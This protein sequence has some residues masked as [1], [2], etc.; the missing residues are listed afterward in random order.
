MIRCPYYSAETDTA[1]TAVICEPEKNGEKY[2]DVHT[3]TDPQKRENVINHFCCANYAEC[4]YYKQYQ[5]SGCSNDADNAAAVIDQTVSGEDVEFNGTLLVSADV[6]TA[7]TPEHREAYDL[8]RHIV[9][10]GITA[11]TAIADMGRSLKTMRDGKLY[12]AMGYETFGDYVENNGDYSFKERQ[13]YNY[14][15]IYENCGEHFLQTNAAIGVTKLELLSKLER[16]EQQEVAEEYDLCGMSVDEVKELIK[17]KQ[18]M[19]EQ[20]SLFAE[21]IEELKNRAE[22]NANIEDKLSEALDKI[23]RLEALEQKYARQT[24]RLKAQVEAKESVA[25]MLKNEVEELKSR[26]VEVATEEPSEAQREAIRSEV[27][28]ELKAKYDADLAAARENQ[29]A[30]IAEIEK[31]LKTASPDETRVVLKMYFER[32]Q[33]DVTAFVERVE[34]IADSAERKKFKAGIAKWLGMIVQQVTDNE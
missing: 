23:K 12:K 21:E 20:L 7:M 8:H 31:K 15:K 26:P 28:A 4:N 32:V 30:E 11:A 9:E 22:E 5:R 27:T 29:R 10:C 25:A 16:A 18:Q 24:E 3:I 6:D 17:S 13:A 14:I 1:E 19:G 2:E 34:D 33:K